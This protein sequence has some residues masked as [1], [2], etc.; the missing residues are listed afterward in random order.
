MF[1]NLSALPP[2]GLYKQ[3]RVITSGQN[4]TLKSGD[5]TEKS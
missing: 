5:I 1:K 4:E 2:L 3:L